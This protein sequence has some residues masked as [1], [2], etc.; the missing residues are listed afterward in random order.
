M[1]AQR[2]MGFTLVETLIGLVL[3][4]L[5]LGITVPRY[6]DLRNRWA[7]RG[8]AVAVSRALFD[9][10]HLARLRSTRVAVR[11]DSAAGRA[12]VIAPPDTFGLYDVRALFGVTLRT[13]RDS[14]AFVPSGLGYGAANAQII[15]SLGPAAETVTVSRAGRVRR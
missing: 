2:Y 12:V 5:A 6:Q 1:N 15:L 8:A 9:A 11:L 14:I 3:I 13:S 7:V 4:G 10:R